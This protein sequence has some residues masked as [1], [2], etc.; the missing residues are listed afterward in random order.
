MQNSGLGVGH[1]TMLNKL[2]VTRSKGALSL[3]QW[4][5]AQLPTT[6]PDATGL[7]ILNSMS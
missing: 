1:D 6:C 2:C 4:K 3:Q 5:G 7:S